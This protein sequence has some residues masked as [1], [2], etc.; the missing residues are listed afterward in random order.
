[1]TI[2]GGALIY[3]GLIGAA[4]GV[5]SLLKPLRFLGIRT[6]MR[7][8]LIL[9]LGFLALMTGVWLPVSETRVATVRTHLDDFVPAYQFSEFHQILIDAPKDRA[10]A[11]IREV[12]P[13]EIRL[14]RTLTC[15]RRFG[16][17]GPPGILNPPE[18]RPILETAT[19]GWFELL[20]DDPGR[21]IVFGHADDGRGRGTLRA[22]EFKRLIRPRSS[23]SR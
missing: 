2:F 6:R 23:R 18:H 13:E 3:L 21:E 22:A 16:R 1:M 5:V 15:I 19:A 4:I 8:L 11:A 14:F 12:T 9:G 10:Y 20:A 17:P 7:G